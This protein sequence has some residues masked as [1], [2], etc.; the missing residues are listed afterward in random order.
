MFLGFA[1]HELNM[2]LLS[3]GVR[4]NATR[5][6]GTAMGISDADVETINAADIRGMFRTPS[7]LLRVNNKL[8]CHALFEEYWRS[9]SRAT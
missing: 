1:F 3:P 5:Y 9:L 4:S 7:A 6:V 8:T 2:E